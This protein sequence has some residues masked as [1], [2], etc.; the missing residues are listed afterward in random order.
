MTWLA[1]YLAFTLLLA[2]LAWYPCCGGGGGGFI[3]CDAC[4]GA[5]D[6]SP[7]YITVYISGIANG[8]CDQCTPYNGTYLVPSVVA[9][10]YVLDL[11]D[12]VCGSG[13]WYFDV[14]IA[15]VAGNYYVSVLMAFA[16]DRHWTWVKYYPEANGLPNCLE[17]VA[18]DIPL[19][20]DHDDQC[21]GTAVCEIDSGNTT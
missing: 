13:D 16:P 6:N 9:C 17:F 15:Y 18:L 20:Q 11:T 19:S 3:H 10:G 1:A 14:S 5:G 7:E 8:T 21:T 12:D 4:A 2:G